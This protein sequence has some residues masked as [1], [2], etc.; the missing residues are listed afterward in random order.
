[1][2]GDF[3]SKRMSSFSMVQITQNKNYILHHHKT[4]NWHMSSAYVYLLFHT[5]PNLVA[6]LV[7]LLKN[8]VGCFT[9]PF[10]SL[11]LSLPEWFYFIFVDKIFKLFLF[12][13]GNQDLCVFG[14]HSVVLKLAPGSVFS[15]VVEI[16]ERTYE[17]PGI[18]PTL[19]S[20]KEKKFTCY[21]ISHIFI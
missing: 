8:K 16:L 20:C 14:P 6:A 3:S 9:V 17:V 12:Q 11:I 5:G 4:W 18:E 15:S 1:M 13:N 19:I 7:L 21:P 2:P 10:G